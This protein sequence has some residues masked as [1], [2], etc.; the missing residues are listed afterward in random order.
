MISTVSRHILAYKKIISNHLFL[1]SSLPIMK[2]RNK[3]EEMDPK[4]QKKL[5]KEEKDF[6]KKFKVCVSVMS[7]NMFILLL[8]G[9]YL[10][11]NMKLLFSE[12]KSVAP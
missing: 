8:P 9:S 6:R 4:K 2:G 12:K 5:E 10:L 3:T 1:L 11:K 7:L